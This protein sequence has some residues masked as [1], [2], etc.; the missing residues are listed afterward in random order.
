MQI[1]TIC[2]FPEYYIFLNCMIGM[3]YKHGRPR[4]VPPRIYL[5]MKCIAHEHGMI[6]YKC[7]DVQTLWV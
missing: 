5:F 3:K 4:G 7:A 1:K 2:F 6:G